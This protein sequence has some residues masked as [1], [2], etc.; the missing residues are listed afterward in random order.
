MIT[1]LIPEPEGV[2]LP[3]PLCS[4]CGKS[5]HAAPAG[6]LCTACTLKRYGWPYTP[7]NNGTPTPC[8]HD[9]H[10]HDICSFCGAIVPIKER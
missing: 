8:P 10:Q 6:G 9:W 7:T 1:D 2:Y 5:L 3:R 4:S